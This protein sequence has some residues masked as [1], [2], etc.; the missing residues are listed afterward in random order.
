MLSFSKTLYTDSTKSLNFFI[1]R[2]KIRQCY[3]NYYNNILAHQ[4]GIVIVFTHVR[5]FFLSHIPVPAHAKMKTNN[6]TLA[7]RQSTL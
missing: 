5:Y 3:S 6:C 1:L 4:I 2:V 7:T